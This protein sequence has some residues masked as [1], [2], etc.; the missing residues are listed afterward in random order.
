MRMYTTGEVIQLFKANGRTTLSRQTISN[1]CKEF[2]PQTDGSLGYFSPTATPSAGGHRRFTDDD[3]T[4][5]TLIAS[6]K[7]MGSTYEEIHVALLNGSRGQLMAS[8]KAIAPA[9][10]RTMQLEAQVIDMQ[11]IIDE[12]TEERD[13]YRIEVATERA[14]RERAD[15]DL[16]AAREELRS[17]YLKVGRLTK[18]EE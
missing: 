1:W 9:V 2:G 6:M 5:L 4:V 18:D 11:E 13:T 14:L 17:L 16:T 12:L 15:K 7:D 3:L 8:S 10:Q